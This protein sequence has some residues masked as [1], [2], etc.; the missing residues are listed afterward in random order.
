MFRVVLGFSFA[1]LLVPAT[2]L[3]QGRSHA[4]TIPTS[5]FFE[6]NEYVIQVPLGQTFVAPARC[7]GLSTARY[8]LPEGKPTPICQID[9]TTEQHLRATLSMG[10]HTQKATYQ[11]Q[12]TMR[13]NG[14]AVSYRM[15]GSMTIDDDPSKYVMELN[16]DP[17]AETAMQ[18]DLGYGSARLDLSES[19]MRALRIVSGA[20]DVVIC[21]NKPN[22]IPMKVLKL[23]SGMA[24]IVVR[25]LEYARA[26]QVFIDNAMGDTKIVV[27]NGLQSRSMVKVDVGSGSCTLLVHKDA[28]VRIVINSSIF[29]SVPIPEGF[30]KTSDNTFCTHSY[31]MHSQEAMTIVVDLGLGSFEMV[32]FE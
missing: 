17:Q 22:A 29:S 21:Y 16:L 9:T 8:S 13:G 30:L 15:A 23:S 4:D 26:E 5:P 11:S 20:A 1:T 14:A 7:S 2:V 31:K 6:L 32:P 10:A 18:M 27:G 25:N 12:S 3:S 24:K 19:H 28:P